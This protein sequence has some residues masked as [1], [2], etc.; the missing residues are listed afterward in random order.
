MWLIAGLGNPGRKYER[1]RHNIGFRVVDELVRRHDLGPLREKFGGQAAMGA[2]ARQR[3]LVLKPME[4]MNHSGF[5]VQRAAQFH[6]TEPAELVV[7]HDE[8]DLPFARLRLKAGGGH[9]GHN[10]I[11]SV[12]EQLGSNDFLRVRIGVGRP[13]RPAAA[14]AA[15]E[16]VQGRVSGHVLGDFPAEMDREIAEL[17]G[18]ASDAVEAILAR[19]IRAA[20]NDFNGAG[21]KPVD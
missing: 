13:E 1:N 3:A 14:G 16:P 20:M 8:I 9:G 21:E 15:S 5:A 6:G 19:G 17:V 2:I 12:A 18:R 4:F 11:R 7:V 10:G